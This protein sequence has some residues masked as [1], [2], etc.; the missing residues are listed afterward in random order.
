MKTITTEN[1]FIIEIDEEAFDD[2]EVLDML[3]ELADDAL[4]LPRLL[5]KTLG[6][7]GKRALYDFVR[8][9]KGRVPPEKAMT[10]FEE[11]MRLAGDNAKNS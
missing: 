2:M 11:V 3:S 6:K 7:D 9:D 5:T 1:G 8:N 4:V 10:L